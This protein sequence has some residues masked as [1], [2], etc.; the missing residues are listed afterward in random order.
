MPLLF[1][2]DSSALVLLFFCWT[3]LSVPFFLWVFVSACCV[4][5]L[6]FSRRDVEKGADRSLLSF[7]RVSGTSLGCSASK[8][9]RAQPCKPVQHNR[10]ATAALKKKTCGNLASCPSKKWLLILLHGL[11]MPGDVPS[12]GFCFLKF[13]PWWP[14]PGLTLPRYHLE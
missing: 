1:R 5:P 7:L 14:T 9:C 13:R 4:S 8:I 12:G 11:L 10:I 6:A 2:F 3:C